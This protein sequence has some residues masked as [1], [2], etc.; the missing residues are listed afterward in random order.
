MIPPTWSDPRPEPRLADVGCGT[1]P[2]DYNLP[3]MPGIYN[4]NRLAVRFETDDGVVDAIDHLV[5]PLNIEGNTYEFF[6]TEAV[7]EVDDPDVVFGSSY[8]NSVR[9]LIIRTP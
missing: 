8:D 5:T 6:A 2:W 1:R 4:M 9:F 7:G 3:P